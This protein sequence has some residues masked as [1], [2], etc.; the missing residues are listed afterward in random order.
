[1]DSLAADQVE[2]VA[3]VGTGVTVPG[4]TAPAVLD[5]GRKVAVRGEALPLRLLRQ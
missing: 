2:V 5:T 3:A 1:V 4:H